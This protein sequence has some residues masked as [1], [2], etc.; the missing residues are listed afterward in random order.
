MQRCLATGITPAEY[1]NLS[2]EESILLL[3]AY[4]DQQNAKWQ[5]TRLI[6]YA[7]A[8]TVTEADKRGEV[9]DLFWLP[10]DPT[11]EQRKAEAEKLY[12]QLQQKGKAF[13]D[14]LRRELS[15]KKAE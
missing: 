15:G 9:Y 2:I 11:P 3:K 13:A 4:E 5:H 7:I 14:E 1:W 12:Q 6:L 8:A 10:G